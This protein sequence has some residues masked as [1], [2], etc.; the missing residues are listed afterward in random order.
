MWSDLDLS[1]ARLL[2]EAPPVA[3]YR[4][5]PRVDLIP[6][7]FDL[8]GGRCCIS[9]GMRHVDADGGRRAAEDTVQL[10][11]LAFTDWT[12]ADQLW[13]LLKTGDMG[14]SFQDLDVLDG[15]SDKVTRAVDHYRKDL[16]VQSVWELKLRIESKARE[17]TVKAVERIALE[18]RTMLATMQELWDDGIVMP[19]SVMEPDPS[20]EALTRF[21][22][23]QGLYGDHTYFVD[24]PVGG[25][26]RVHGIP[27]ALMFRRASELERE[28]SAHGLRVMAA[29]LRALV[30]LTGGREGASLAQA[31]ASADV[32]HRLNRIVGAFWDMWRS[33]V[34]S[35]NAEF[36]VV[37]DHERR[38]VKYMDIMIQRAMRILVKQAVEGI[39][40]YPYAPLDRANY[41]NRIYA[42]HE[43][44]ARARGILHV[45]A[46]ATTVQAFHDAH[47]E[48][49]RLVREFQTQIIKGVADPYRARV[50]SS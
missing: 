20:K 33:P 41:W 17:R 49:E 10:L 42:L 25:K 45:Y 6:R 28:L 48:R 16:W 11:N 12:I 44:L 2:G 35:A 39:G 4:Q 3:A 50:A 31:V 29:E 14:V 30:S 21:R 13:E 5:G 47:R 34:F 40:L 22:I 7:L 19:A 1:E 36:E 32:H 18:S 46:C 15:G 27:L 24:R 9:V 8:R 43:A 23:N 38:A 37:A 26:I